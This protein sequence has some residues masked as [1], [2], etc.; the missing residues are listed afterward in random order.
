MSNVNPN[1][2]KVAGRERQG[3]DILHG[4]HKQKHSQSVV[5]GRSASHVRRERP[6]LIPGPPPRGAAPLRTTRKTANTAAKKDSAGKRASTNKQGS[7]KRGTRSA[8]QKRASSR[9][10]FDP[11]PATSPVGGAFGK[12]PSAPRRKPRE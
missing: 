1:H 8:A 7:D 10:D 6:A 5:R 12:A 4:R 9:Y 11:I 3:E 2:Y